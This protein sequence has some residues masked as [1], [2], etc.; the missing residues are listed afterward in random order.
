[1]PRSNS[2]QYLNNRK[3]NDHNIESQISPDGRNARNMVSWYVKQ[4]TMQKEEWT[5][6]I[7]V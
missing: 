6:D 5:I 2:N 1:M 7:D 4:K 3:D